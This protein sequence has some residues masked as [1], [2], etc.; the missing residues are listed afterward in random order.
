MGTPPKVEQEQ[1]PSQYIVD[2][3]T[4]I[5][6]KPVTLT[7]DLGGNTWILGVVDEKVLRMV[8]IQLTT[9]RTVSVKLEKEDPKYEPKCAKQ[10]TFT[11]DCWEKERG[12][13]E[14]K[15]EDEG[16]EE[17]EGEGLENDQA[18]NY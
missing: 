2:S 8:K 18:Q 7:L 5:Y 12:K 4:T 10:Q 9:P 11:E 3:K 16:E 17:G 14:E 6:G 1:A 13:G 15:G